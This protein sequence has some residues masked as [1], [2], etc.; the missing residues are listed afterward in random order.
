MVDTNQSLEQTLSSAKLGET[1]DEFRVN[2]LS[3]IQAV[4]QL[5]DGSCSTCVT[6]TAVGA[7]EAGGSDSS[8]R[9]ARARSRLLRRRRVDD[10]PQSRR[11][12]AVRRVVV[13]RE[14]PRQVI[15][16]RRPLPV[17][18]SAQPLQHEL[19]VDP[20]HGRCQ[21]RSRAGAPQ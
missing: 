20:R 7:S 5:S 17:V 1:D 8:Q 4:S 14:Q 15:L 9:T 13:Q 3:E 6:G 18:A 10:R 2:R 12:L 16:E 19:P 21:M 11:D